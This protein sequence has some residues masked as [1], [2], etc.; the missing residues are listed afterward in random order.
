MYCIDALLANT[1]HYIHSD[2]AIDMEIDRAFEIYQLS[3]SSQS[4]LQVLSL[5]WLKLFVF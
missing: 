4:Y 2:T 5:S 1:A 3:D